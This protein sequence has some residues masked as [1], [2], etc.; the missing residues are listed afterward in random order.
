MARK[1]EKRLDILWA[2]AVKVCAGYRCER[3]GSPHTFGLESHHF[4]PRSLIG[5][6][7]RWEIEN[8]FCL[9]IRCHGLAKLQRA[10]FIIW[11]IRQ[12]GRKW[13]NRLFELSKIIKGIIDRE[14]KKKG[15]EAIIERG[16]LAWKK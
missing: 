6:A 10:E 15:L 8:G 13:Y 3:C 7:L 5:F 16:G 2:T 1:E 11:A 12:R 4:F 14:L 9:C